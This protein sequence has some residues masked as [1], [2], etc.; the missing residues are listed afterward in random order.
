MEITI[1]TS[2]DEITFA[3]Y[4]Q[5]EKDSNEIKDELL[6]KVLVIANLCKMNKVDVM[7]FKAIDLENTFSLLTN[8]LNQT[9]ELVKTFTLDGVKFGFIPDLEGITASE[10]IDLDTFL[11]TDPQR[12][13]AVLYRPIVKENKG[14]YTIEKYK[15]TDDYYDTMAQAPASAYVSSIVFFYNLGKELLTHIPAYIQSNLTQQ[16]RTLLE[17]NGVGIAQ[18]M[19]SLE[20]IEPNITKF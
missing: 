20:M 4:R 13:L 15:G 6:L 1:P 19:Q 8:T 17:A 5:V 3:Q 18:L 7:H 11:S 9:P 12:A 16:E 10:Y 2:L 14:F